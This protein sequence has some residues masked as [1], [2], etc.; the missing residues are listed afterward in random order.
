MTLND[1]IIIA[2][3]QQDGAEK[4]LCKFG[5]TELYFSVDAPAIQAY[6]GT[7]TVTPGTEARIPVVSVDIGRVVLFFTSRQ[8]ARLRG[9]IAGMPLVEAA[10][11]VCKMPD[12]DGVLIQSDAAAWIAVNKEAVRRLIDHIQGQS[13]K[14]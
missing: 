7:L 4:H 3:A 10:A 5:S 12:V 6:D 11:M 8:D 9:R 2:D 14:R 13:Q 1:Y